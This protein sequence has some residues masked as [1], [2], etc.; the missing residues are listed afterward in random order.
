MDNNKNDEYGL[1]QYEKVFEEIQDYC[2]ELKK[3]EENISFIYKNLNNNNTH[4]NPQQ[5]YLIDINDY[6]NFKEQI[7]YNTF[8]NNIQDY[9]D[10]MALKFTIQ[11]SENKN[12][13]NR[14]L[15][16]TIVNSM[17]ELYKLLKEQHEYILINTEQSQKLVEKENEGIYSYSIISNELILDIKGEILHFSHNNNIINLK[18][19]KAEEREILKIIN[20]EKSENNI[21]TVNGNFNNLE[22]YQK[23]TDWLIKFI[24]TENNF[25]KELK[26]EKKEKKKYFGYLIEYTAYLNWEKNL[27]LK[28][29]RSIIQRYLDEEKSQLSNEE[30][31]QITNNLIKHNISKKNPIQ[32]LKFESIEKLKSFNRVDNLIILSKELFFLINED[33]T[34]H[35]DENKIEYEITDKSI[36]IFINNAKLS[37]HNKFDNIIYSY[38]YYNLYLLTKINIYQKNYYAEKKSSMIYI[39]S[40]EFLKKYKECFL[41]KDIMPFIK[42][43]K[44]GDKE[45]FDLIETI[46]NGLI[47]S[48]KE[49]LKSFKLEVKPI[50]PKEIALN[51]NTNFEYIN[52]FDKIFLSGGL[53]INFCNINSLTKEENENLRNIVKFFFIKEKILILFGNDKKVFGEIGNLNNSNEENI[54]DIDYLISVKKNDTKNNGTNLLNDILK[55][56]EDYNKFYQNIYDSNQKICF[57]YKISEE[58]ILNILNFKRKEEYKSLNEN[59]IF[60]IN[61][62]QIQTAHHESNNIINNNNQNNNNIINNNDNNNQ[63]SDTN[64]NNNENN[65]KFIPNPFSAAYQQQNNEYNN[66]MNNNYNNINE[67]TK[68]VLNKMEKINLNNSTV[69]ENNEGHHMNSNQNSDSRFNNNTANNNQNNINS[70][71]N[72]NNN[73]YNINNIN[74]Y[75]NTNQMPNNNFNYP[76]PNQNQIIQP[77]YDFNKIQK[78]L[79]LIISFFKSDQMIKMK[80]CR[81]CNDAWNFKENLYL[82][83][84]SWIFSIFF[85]LFKINEIYNIIY[86]NL[87]NILTNDNNFIF[88]NFFGM[89]S[90]GFKQYL[91]NLDEKSLQENLFKNSLI[92]INQISLNINIGYKRMFCDFYFITEEFLN[93]LEKVFYTNVKG[94]FLNAECILMNPKIFAF[95]N[96]NTIYIGNLGDSYLF[97][98]EKIIYYPSI[99]IKNEIMN[100]IQTDSINYFNF[101]LFSGELIPNNYNIQV[102][103]INQNSINNNKIIQKLKSYIYFDNFNK[104]LIHDTNNN[105]SQED[106]F[107]IKKE[108]FNK[109]KY[110]EIIEILN[111]YIQ[112]FEIINEQNQ[113][114]SNIMANMKI[115]D[116]ELLKKKFSEID[117]DEINKNDIL[118]EPSFIKSSENKNIS[119][120]NNFI[121][122]KKDV[123]KIFMNKEQISEK[124]IRKM[125]AGN[126]FNTIFINN[127]DEKTILIGSIMNKENTF[128]L[129]YILNYKYS[130]DIEYALEIIK[131]EGALSYIYNH[132][133][134]DD[135]EYIVKPIFGSKGMITGYVYRYS[136][137]IL[138]EP[139][140]EYYL[141]ENFKNV[142]H[143]FNYYMFLNNKLENCKG[144]NNKI[145]LLSTEYCIVNKKWVQRFK[146]T[147]EYEIIGKEIKSGQEYQDIKINNNKDNYE[148]TDKNIYSTLKSFNVDTLIKYNKELKKINLE[149]DYDY[150]PET[151]KITYELTSNIPDKIQS[152]DFIHNFEI[153]PKHIIE[154]Y[155]NDINQFSNFIDFQIID[156]FIMINFPS[157]INTKG[158]CYSLICELN[159]Y[160]NSL[161]I[162]SVL[163]YYKKF[164]LNEI[165]ERENNNL[166]NLVNKKVDRYFISQEEYKET[167][168]NDE[169]Y[170]FKYSPNS[171][172]FNNS[173]DN[174]NDNN[175]I[176]NDNYIINNDINNDYNFYDAENN[177]NNNGNDEI[178]KVD[179][180]EYNLDYQVAYPFINSNFNQPPLI[181]LDNI[182]ATCYMNATLQC[183]SNI[184]PFVN[185]FKY[186]SNLINKVRNELTYN[187]K[188]TLSS[189]FKLLIEKLWPND[190]I[191]NPKKSYSP[192]EFKAK[193]SAMNE[194]FKGVA[195]NDSKD[196]VNFIIM[197]LHEELNEIQNKIMDTSFNLD[198][199]NMQLMY[200]SFIQNFQANNQSEISRLF[201]AYNF[202]MTE[203]QNC[204][205][206]SYNFQT[207]FFLI[208][209]LEEIRKYKLN[210]NQ[211]NN[212]NNIIDNNVVNIYDCLDYER[213]ETLMDGT[214]MMYCNYCRITCNSK[215]STHLC[216]CPEILIII[217]NRG[218]G[219]QFNVKINFIEQLDLSNYIYMKN[220]GCYYNL[221]GVITHIGES[222]MGG[223]FIAYCKNPINNSWNKYND[224]IVTPVNDFKS[225]VID[226]ATPY[227]LFYQKYH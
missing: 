91:T 78:Y 39:F 15:K 42:G 90:D 16:Q 45:I 137:S 210:L 60:D 197:T 14:K 113:I 192:Y 117:F 156:S 106:V 104:K 109:I 178:K 143:L 43:D 4:K 66:N 225:E 101:L 76:N 203:C 187:T 13:I 149:T 2:I 217:L 22:D 48:I 83:N 10:T 33:E 132:L 70:M 153:L 127:H 152:L 200:N 166:H 95:I 107:I 196:L 141:C 169:C 211:M 49:N 185:F 84:N 160:T 208:F 170:T 129:L 174:F 179:I 135:E 209:P 222:G 131:K 3:F 150:F 213:K 144:S 177:N 85:P 64:I 99:E 145:N 79:S 204:F 29:V 176:N 172:N 189:S 163:V 124:Y 195:A 63:F 28:S 227:L 218:K 23:L 215:M 125:I 183:F 40:K 32:S 114:L 205:T 158:K 1:G 162:Q 142:I 155:I 77:I 74:I 212:F 201:Y 97:N 181:G 24:S 20:S 25:K 121:I 128:D 219:I 44:K 73:I 56:E 18:D 89:L 62:N 53:Y 9:K 186:N 214:N 82:I 105:L 119:F 130:N 46:P 164:Q 146:K 47:N 36:D 134:F 191:N 55:K 72:I 202:N 75:N 171:M 92:N 136:D 154:Q 115:E 206:R 6:N 50:L 58:L 103:N 207:Y 198:Q 96:D 122:V 100:N 184:E 126:G 138:N 69:I 26:L 37:F 180:L 190:Y 161:D 57:E 226:F 86:T 52:D 5:T 59:Q 81:N 111:N 168:E 133:T 11:Q 157:D 88:N 165:F 35:N 30:K 98:I 102:L 175:I 139:F 67:V 221:I 94:Y 220:T 27:Q 68:V 112:K 182:G 224:S 51:T 71:N 21:S 118:L 223:H 173:F 216:T 193:I 93:E 80:I 38:L 167:L 148:F 151:N 108:L 116:I 7:E 8:I 54:I 41:F 123:I 31:Q 140:N 87:N 159:N 61:K 19:L 12:D 120:Y 17:H 147:F 199:R 34:N 65:K 194:L 188:Y 110:K